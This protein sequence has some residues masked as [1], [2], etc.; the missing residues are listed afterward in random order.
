MLVFKNFPSNLETLLKNVLE[1]FSEYQKLLKQDSCLSQA[2]LLD[3]SKNL[4]WFKQDSCLSALVNTGPG[5][6]AYLFTYVSAWFFSKPSDPDIRKHMVPVC[7][8]KASTTDKSMCT[9]VF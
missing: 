1:Y 7:I 8:L 9:Q 3:S 2:L 6:I 4:V 5:K